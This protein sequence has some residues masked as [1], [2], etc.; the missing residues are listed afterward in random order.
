MNVGNVAITQRR[1]WANCRTNQ[2]TVMEGIL[3]PDQQWNAASLQQPAHGQRMHASVQCK[4]RLT[5]AK[6]RRRSL[7]D[8]SSLTSSGMQPPWPLARKCTSR[9][10][11]SKKHLSFV[12]MAAIAH[13]SCKPE[14]ACL[15]FPVKRP[16][17]EKNGKEDGTADMRSFTTY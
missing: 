12:C 7:K 10:C 11:A 8:S 16:S 15:P 13:L 3:H 6:F 1:A 9:A 17:W 4:A 14:G 5:D 2:E